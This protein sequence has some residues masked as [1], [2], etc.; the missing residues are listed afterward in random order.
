MADIRPYRKEVDRKS[1]TKCTGMHK[2]T[3]YTHAYIY[4]HVLD[5]V[6]IGNRIYLKS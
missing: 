4:C 5:G 2:D 6:W 1:T 3:T